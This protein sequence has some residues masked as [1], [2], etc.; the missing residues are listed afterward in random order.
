MTQRPVLRVGVGARA[1]RMLI[2]KCG[3]TGRACAGVQGATDGSP[4][5]KVKHFMSSSAVGMA[6]RQLDICNALRYMFKL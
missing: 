1:L 4:K 2:K 6:W 5:I 3:W